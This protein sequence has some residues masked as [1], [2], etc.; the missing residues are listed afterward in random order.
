MRRVSWADSVVDRRRVQPQRPIQRRSATIDQ[1]STAIF[2]SDRFRDAMP[3]MET[4]IIRKLVRGVKACRV[5]PVCLKCDPTTLPIDINEPYWTQTVAPR[6][7]MCIALAT[8]TALVGVY[9][10]SN[11]QGGGVRMLRLCD[12]AVATFISHARAQLCPRTFSLPYAPI[13]ELNGDSS[14]LPSGTAIEALK[15]V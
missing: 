13:Q 5:L 2:A 10:C 12:P 1:V 7:L 11:I 14:T 8:P 15:F 9:E 4:T 6:A 3:V